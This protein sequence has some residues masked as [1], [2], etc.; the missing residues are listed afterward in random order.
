MDLG[1]RADSEGDGERGREGKGEEKRGRGGSGTERKDAAVCERNR[2]RRS[3]ERDE[4][5]RG[6]GRGAREGRREG[7]MRK[8]KGTCSRSDN[9]SIRRIKTNRERRRRPKRGCSTNRRSYAM[10]NVDECGENG[11]YRVKCSLKRPLVIWRVCIKGAG[12]RGRGRGQGWR[13]RRREKKSRMGVF[14]GPRE[15]QNKKLDE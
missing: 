4:T 8:E 6:C 12:R 3:S 5:G 13:G 1:S 7:R 14:V 15:G 2:K 10:V 9:N 11:P